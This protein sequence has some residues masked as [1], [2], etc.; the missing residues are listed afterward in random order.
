V[1]YKPN[2]PDSRR[3]ALAV[4]QAFAA[5]TGEPYS[6]Y[7]GR[8]ALDVRTDLGGLNRSTVPKVLIE[9][10]NMRNALDAGRLESP[11]YRQREAA[12]LAR[13]LVTFLS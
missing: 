2:A 4:R 8:D 3:L 10:A 9:T 1:I 7:A 6:T 13:G 5:V 11:A 12:A